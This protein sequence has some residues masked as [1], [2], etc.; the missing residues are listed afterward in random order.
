[1]AIARRLIR[2]L[3][4]SSNIGGTMS[5]KTN[6]WRA[7]I[8]G[9]V[10]GLIVGPLAE[11]AL[12]RYGEYKSRLAEEAAL[13]AGV[14]LITGIT[15]SLYNPYYRPL[16]FVLLFSVASYLVH[17]FFN[18]QRVFLLWQLIGILAVTWFAIF[19]FLERRVWDISVLQT[20]VV[21]WLI[22]LGVMFMINLVYGSILHLSAS[23]YSRNR[24]V[25]LP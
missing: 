8:L 5:L 19:D 6:L 18:T 23:H 17:R 9:A 15:Y 20:S 21:I 12:V 7:G 4:R 10:N 1:M 22:C 25:N 2:A 11:I 16:I 3:D 13:R 14:P 24:K